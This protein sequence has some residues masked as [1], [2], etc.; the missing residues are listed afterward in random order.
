MYD[1]FFVLLFSLL[2]KSK[3]NLPTQKIAIL[4]IGNFVTYQN[5][6]SNYIEP[7]QKQQKKKQ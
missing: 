6:R 3:K 1:Y 5:Q 2:D 7:L 4:N